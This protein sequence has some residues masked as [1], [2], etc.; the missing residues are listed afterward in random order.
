MA[1]ASLGVQLSEMEAAVFAFLIRKGEA[2]LADIK[3]LTGLSGPAALELAQRLSTQVIVRQVPGPRTKFVLAD[4]LQERYLRPGSVESPTNQRDS[5]SA[6]HARATEQVTEQV[7]E[8]PT[9]QVSPLREL[10]STQWSIVAH[11]DV[12]R[13]LAELM[14][15][16]GY[17][18]RPHFK[19]THIEPLIAGGIL[20]MTVP[21]KPTS[22]KQKYVL[23]QA[24]LKLKAL[25]LELDAG[26][27]EKENAE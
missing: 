19:A 18:Q 14:R 4:H 23:T 3:A 11:A 27:P 21:D 5:E 8:K 6:E 12:P 1:Q 26:K 13:S 15:I 16:A 17:T 7:G 10:S 2:E 9:D 22:S 24:G 20:R 25:R